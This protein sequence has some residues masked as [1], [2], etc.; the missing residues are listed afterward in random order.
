MVI[1]LYFTCP[2]QVVFCQVSNPAD[3]TMSFLMLRLSR[4]DSYSSDTSQTQAF[5]LSVFL[6]LSYRTRNAP[7]PLIDFSYVVQSRH[8]QAV[9][10]HCQQVSPK[11]CHDKRP[12]PCTFIYISF[13]MSSILREGAFLHR[14]QTYI[15]QFVVATLYYPTVVISASC[16]T[17]P[18]AIS[19]SNNYVLYIKFTSN[20][21]GTIPVILIY[22]RC[23]SEFLKP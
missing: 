11:G 3:I 14:Q 8:H 19:S 22:F 17:Q 2:L 21:L 7:R 1:C 5:R 20:F 18:T 9:E 13:K 12:P 23:F 4:L 6:T 15:V 10:V 16:M